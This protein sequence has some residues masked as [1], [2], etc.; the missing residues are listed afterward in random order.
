MKQNELRKIIREEISTVLNENTSL[1]VKGRRPPEDIAKK[2][3]GLQS[4][5]H[6]SFDDSN[7][8]DTSMNDWYSG[9]T[10]NIYKFAK[11]WKSLWPT[12]KLKFDG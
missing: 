4:K 2:L 12:A 8:S 7:G 3:M 6:L 11:A 10:T 1:N 5:Y 9:S